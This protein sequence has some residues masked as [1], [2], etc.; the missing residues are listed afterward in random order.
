MNGPGIQLNKKVGA[1]QP[2]RKKMEIKLLIS[3]IL[4]YSP[5]KNSAKPIAA[6]SVLYPETS[7]ASAS[8]K[9]N[10]A[11]FVSAKAETKN[12]KNIL[13]NSE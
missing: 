3:S 12:I 2:P 11:R 10:G 4:A 13:N 9:S 7:S 8:G 6:Y 5:K 1:N